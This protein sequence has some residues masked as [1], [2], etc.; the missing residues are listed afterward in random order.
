MKK[1]ALVIVMFGILFSGLKAQDCFKYF[2]EKKGTSLEYTNYDKKDKVTSTTI[3]TVVDKRTS[4][5]VVTVDYKTETTP[6]DYDTIIV[7]EFSINCEGG[8]IKIDMSNYYSGMDMGAY[9]G[10]E[11]EVQGDEI[12]FPSNPKAG[13]T[14]NDANMTIIVKNGGATFM[15]IETKIFNRKV[16]ALE[17]VS[18]TAGNFETVKITYD[19]S[20][21]MGFINSQAKSAEWYSEKYGMIKSESYDKKGKLESSVKLTKIISE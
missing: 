13:Q 12:E 6:V 10:M 4:G 11:I 7:Q 18:T 19:V 3:R 2:P 8:V 20:V 1:F 16:E 9:Q 21:K 5:N 17:S 14:L 15:T